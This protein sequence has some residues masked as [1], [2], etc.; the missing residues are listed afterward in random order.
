MAAI[1]E[2]EPEWSYLPGSIPEVVRRLLRRCLTK[3]LNGR[4]RDLGDARADLADASLTRHS[5]LRR[6]ATVAATAAGLVIVA[7]LIFSRRAPIAVTVPSEYVQLTNVNDAAMTPS[8]SLD[9]RLLAFKR[10]DDA[11]LGAGQIYVK[12]LPN[13]DAVRVTDN[14]RQKY[15]PVFTPD[16]ERVAYTQ[17]TGE[18]PSLSW[19]MPVVGGTP[20]RL[21][22]NASRD[23]ERTSHASRDRHRV[24]MAARSPCAVLPTEEDGVAVAPDG[25]SLIT[26]VGR[27][28]SAVWLHDAAG[29][30]PVTSEGYAS[31]PRWSA[32]GT[33]VFY[34]DSKT[35]SAS[36]PIG[37][38]PAGDLRV[39]D[40][41]SGKTETILPGVS[42]AAYDLS[43]DDRTVVFTT[44]VDGESQLWIGPVDRSASPRVLARAADQPSFL[45]GDTIVFRDTSSSANYLSRIKSDGSARAHVAPSPIVEKFGVSPDSAWIAAVVPLAKNDPR[46]SDPLAVPY[47]TMA[48]PVGGGPMRN[49]CNSACRVVWSV[50]GRF[51]YLTVGQVLAL[52]IAAGHALPDLP[53]TGVSAGDVPNQL[54]N[55]RLIAERGVVA[56]SDPST[57]LFT[58]VDLRANLFQIPLH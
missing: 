56:R 46:L 28:V 9:G 11:F 21:L 51:L 24:D 55:M 23:H 37:P 16:G 30:R 14:P 52:P 27:R 38:A 20:T 18:G 57:Y 17:L 29:D 19:D 42:V 6:A 40:I 41:K 26:S 34:R 25:R 15:G 1:L 13:G 45:G 4:L 53:S 22:P 3:N 12:V 44:M 7:F 8:L 43:P 49:L 54:P 2:R 39:V 35:A 32:D 10:G 50:D 58:R 47:V 36:N 33:K 5:F 48:I 31:D